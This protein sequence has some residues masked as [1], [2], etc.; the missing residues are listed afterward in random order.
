MIN[1]PKKK[2]QLLVKIKTPYFIHKEYAG[3]NLTFC[4]AEYALP[5]N[6]ISD[7]PLC[8][9]VI[10]KITK[11]KKAFPDA[12]IEF[13]FN[14]ENPAFL[15]KVIGRTKRCPGDEHNQD[16]G[17][18]VARAKATSRACVISKAIIKAAIEGLEEELKKNLRIFEEWH[19]K[20]KSIVRGV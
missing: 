5:W 19:E 18:A 4:I 3:N 17:D 11:V 6:K 12:H 15:F 7:A 1:K 2:K 9:A 13:N 16:V 10:T 20:E 8:D 14:R